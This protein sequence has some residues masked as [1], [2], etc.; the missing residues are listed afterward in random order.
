MGIHPLPR[1]QP[2]CADRG[3]TRKFTKRKLKE[4]SED[5]RAEIVRLYEIEHVQQKDIAE[6]F[7]VSP[8]MVG[9]LVKDSE[10]RPEK[11]VARR[12]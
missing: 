5:V 11:L 8:K 6:R 2:T 7:R 4:L 9:R 12:R 10:K 1:R 3:L